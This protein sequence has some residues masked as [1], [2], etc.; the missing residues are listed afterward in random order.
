[1]VNTVTFRDFEERDIA[2]IYK[3]KNDEKLN[4]MIVGDFHPFTY[5]EAEKWVHGCMGEHE[6]FKF[7]AICTDDEEKRIVGWI[8]L[9][10]ID[11]TNR[12]ACHHGIVIGDNE[13]RDG[14]AMF[15]AM[16]FTMEY[17]FISLHVH[18][19]YGSCLSVHKV[20]PHMLNALG[21]NLEGVKRDAV[22]RNERF[23]DIL[24]YSMLEEEYNSLNES[25]TFDTEHLIMRFVNSMKRSKSNQ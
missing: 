16:V 3:C 20:S 5:E 1:M 14:V 22:C 21:F 12:S 9:S 6:T 23:Y 18:R 19:L 8:S 2:F 15:E 13:Y 7:W 4:S 24:N 11:S 25:G 17:A 10:N